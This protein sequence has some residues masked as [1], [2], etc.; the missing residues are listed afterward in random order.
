[1]LINLKFQK[2]NKLGKFN[3]KINWENDVFIDVGIDMSG[4][5]FKPWDTAN[6]DA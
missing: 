4:S 1:M 3:V 5:G 2:E 6:V